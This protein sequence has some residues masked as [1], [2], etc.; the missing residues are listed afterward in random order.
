V[1]ETMQWIAADETEKNGSILTM[2][3]FSKM[4]GRRWMMA[5]PERS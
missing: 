4:G 1:E 2:T 3:G 5:V